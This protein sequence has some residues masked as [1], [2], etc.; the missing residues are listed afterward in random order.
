MVGI[1][2]ATAVGGSGASASGSVTVGAGADL[3]LL[4]F[5]ALEPSNL[6]VTSLTF[7]GI[8][9]TFLDEIHSSGSFARLECWYMLNP[10]VQTATVA[11]GCTGNTLGLGFVSYVLSGVNQATPFRPVVKSASVGTTTNISNTT[12]VFTPGDLSIDCVDIGDTALTPGANQVA[13]IATTMTGSPSPTDSFRSSHGILSAPQT[14]SWTWPGS[15]TAAQ[16][17]ATMIGIPDPIAA[18]IPHPTFGPF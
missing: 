11:V 13:D 5:V 2:S 10:T 8:S 16:L 9:L 12:S 3:M 17:I 7:G 18:G 1:Q 14:F 4:V 6:P 15:F